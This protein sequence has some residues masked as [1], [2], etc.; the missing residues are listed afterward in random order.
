MTTY[1]IYKLCCKDDNEPDIYIGSTIDL[2]TRKSIH[3]STCY[4]QNRDNYDLKVYKKIRDTGGWDNWNFVVIEEIENCSK[5][6]A[7]IREEYYRESLKA[8]LNSMSCFSGVVDYN[9]KEEYKKQYRKANKEKIKLKQKQWYEDN[10]DQILSN[11]S[12]PYN[13]ECGS[14]C[15]HNDK[16]RHFKTKKHKEYLANV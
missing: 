12:K 16:A 8:N 9:T 11:R 10:K 4:N 2:E 7:H 5:L 14:V 15:R 6:D 13:C 3:K 1:Y